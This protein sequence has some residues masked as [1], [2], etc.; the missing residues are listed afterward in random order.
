M[1]AM[2][3]HIVEI[4]EIFFRVDASKTSEK[5]NVRK[6]KIRNENENTCLLS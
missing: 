5:G 2:K 3:T 6:I 1:E 4:T